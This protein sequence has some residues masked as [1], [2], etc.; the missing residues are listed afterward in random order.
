MTFVFKLKTCARDEPVEKKR[1]QSRERETKT[2]D[3][4]KSYG[5]LNRDNKTPMLT[6][7]YGLSITAKLS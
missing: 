7:D 4:K 6:S 3:F 1:R 2:L 5:D